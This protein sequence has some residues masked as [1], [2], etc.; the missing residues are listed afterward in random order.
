MK[1]LIIFFI[2]LSILFANDNYELKLYE[3]IIPSIFK[4][5]V[6]VYVDKKSEELLKNSDKFLIVDNCN[7]ADILIGKYFDNLE[8]S[9][10]NKPYF[11]TSY[12]SYKNNKNSFGAFYWR[13]GRP[14]I[15]F[16]EEIIKKQNLTLPDS[17]SKYIR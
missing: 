3:K 2:S 7:N 4:H 6:Y 9:C 10:K 13:K 5:K 1:Y 12:K 17:F 16:R 11:S 15:K 8:D 14:Q